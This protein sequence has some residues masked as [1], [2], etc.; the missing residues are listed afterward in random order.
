M[1]TCQPLGTGPGCDSGSTD[2][3]VAP[4]LPTRLREAPQTAR[5]LYCDIHVPPS[6][7][8]VDMTD[9]SPQ[10]PLFASNCRTKVSVGKQATFRKPSRRFQSP[11]LRSLRAW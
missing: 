6:A 8:A 10:Y 4:G 7:E 3:S 2:A 5:A 9:T 1:P 11:R